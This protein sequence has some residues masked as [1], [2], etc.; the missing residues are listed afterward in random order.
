M[1]EPRDSLSLLLESLE[2][3][4][5]PGKTGRQELQRRFA[6]RPDVAGEIDVA[7]PAGA[8]RVRNLVMTNDAAIQGR[9]LLS[10]YNSGRQTS[11]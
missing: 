1:V 5:I 7:H 2:S 4:R 3:I 8:D 9:S 6:T 10:A 11:R